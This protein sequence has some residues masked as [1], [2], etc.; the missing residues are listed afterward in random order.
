[1]PA[2]KAMSSSVKTPG[3]YLLIN[4]L[5]AG[6]GTG[7]DPIRVLLIAHK[8]SSGDIT[9]D[10]E[11]RR[12]LAGPDA[13]AQALG[14]GALGHLWA[15]PAFRK[16]GLLQLDLVAPVAPAGATAGLTL[17]IVSTPTTTHTFEFDIAGRVVTV[18]WFVGEVL[19]TF[20][21]RVIAAINSVR[22]I[23]WVASAGAGAGD[24]DVDAKGGGTWGNDVKVAVKRLRGIDVT[25]TG[26][27]NLAGGSSEFDVTNVLG[28]VNAQE[29]H[30]IAVATSNADYEITSAS[31][32]VARVKAHI[33]TFNNGLDA[34]VQYGYAAHT[35]TITN[36]KAG[37]VARNSEWMSHVFGQNARSLPAELCGSEV[38]DAVKWYGIRPN[39][40]RIGNRHPDLFGSADPV[41]D[42][43]TPAEREDLLNS[44]V[45]P[46]DF[47]ANGEELFVVNPITTHSLDGSGNPDFRAYY[48]TDVFGI[49]A[50]SKDMRTFLPQQYPNASIS[51]NLPPGADSLPAGVVE[52][53]DVEA[54]VHARL[55]SWVPLGVVN[56][57][58]LEEQIALGNVIVEIDASDESQVN[59]FIPSKIL[60]PLAKFSG[61]VH[62]VG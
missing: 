24:V 12:A 25:I 55:R 8:L 51:P 52:I 13:V 60:K 41:G 45:T 36:V 2:P 23:A 16:Y 44:G 29:Y 27:G 57:A 11:L 21:A 53:R 46:L 42:K 58:H 38:G 34:L 26:A 17:A 49:M 4:L 18:D 47:V 39:Y 43:L 9:A 1:M 35:G 20:R 19:A 28:L 10:T 14:D 7:T 3:F 54:T 48:Q 31:S 59:V 37:A 22:P 56:G 15:I 30:I 5:A 32:N 33:E 6:S 61:V 62:K 50:V 40:N